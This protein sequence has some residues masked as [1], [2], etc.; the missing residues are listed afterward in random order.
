MTDNQ[1]LCRME[2]LENHKENKYMAVLGKKIKNITRQKIQ[3]S[4]GGFCTRP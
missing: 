1:R 2:L 4:I 3:G